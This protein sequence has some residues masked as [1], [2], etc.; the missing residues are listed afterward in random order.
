MTNVAGVNARAHEV[1]AERLSELL[2]RCQRAVPDVEVTPAEFSQYLVSRLLGDD[3]PGLALTEL[4]VE[5]LFLACACSRGD[6]NALTAF[7]LRSAPEVAGYV[8][9]V[10]PSPVFADE[11]KQQL[12]QRL[13]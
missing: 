9:R 5:D 4:R 13:F 1:V 7:E 6:R 11:V 2:A 8:A 12:R 3:D 10:D